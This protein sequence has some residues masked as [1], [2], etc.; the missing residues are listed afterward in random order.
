MRWNGAQTAW[1][2][3]NIKKWNEQSK[4]GVTAAVT[5]VLDR[6]GPARVFS[7]QLLYEKLCAKEALPAP[8]SP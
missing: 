5:P 1:L 8:I 6:M 7:K 2:I 4:T 3:C